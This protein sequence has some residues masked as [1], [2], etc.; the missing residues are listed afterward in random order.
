M[1][2][3][4]TVRLFALSLKRRPRKTPEVGSPGAAGARW[5]DAGRMLAGRRPNEVPERLAERLAERR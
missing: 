3:N 4:K 5:P 1:Q 2:A